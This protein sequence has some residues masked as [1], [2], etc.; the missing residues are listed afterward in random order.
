MLK[1]NFR[2]K[3]NKDFRV[4]YQNGKVIPSKYFVLYY[5]PNSSEFLRIGFSA[6]KK[7]GNSIVRSRAKRILRE[8]VRKHLEKITVGFDIIF[9]ARARI[10]GIKSTEIENILVNLLVKN[11]LLNR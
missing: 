1:D 5:K 9:I 3:K 6:S 7:I 4:V 8:A 10:K 2:L 11:K